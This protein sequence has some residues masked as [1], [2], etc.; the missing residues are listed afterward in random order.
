MIDHRTLFELER[1]TEE[2]SAGVLA[3][4]DSMRADIAEL[5]VHMRQAIDDGDP[6]RAEGYAAEAASV[7]AYSLR[8]A[9]DELRYMLQGFADGAER[10]AEDALE[11]RRWL[12]YGE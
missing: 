5:T 1:L 6:S 10:A 8:G 7:C 12:D 3:N 4:L 9:F 11:H 2:T